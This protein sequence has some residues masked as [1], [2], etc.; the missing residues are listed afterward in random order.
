MFKKTG[1]LFLSTALVSLC[2]TSVA[3][4]DTID[5]QQKNL[6]SEIAVAK[7]SNVINAKQAAELD[8]GMREFSKLKRRLRDAHND[9]LS[10][11]DD[12]ELNKS[13]NEV[14]QKFEVIAEDGKV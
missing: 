13:L 3:L 1:Q 2:M 8:K 7:S 14:S 6:I 11:E 4:A 12:A 5:E 9:A 10:Q